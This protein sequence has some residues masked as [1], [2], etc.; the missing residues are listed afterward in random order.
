MTTTTN[1]QMNS[2]TLNQNTNNMTEEGTMDHANN[3]INMVARMTSAFRMGSVSKVIAAAA[4]GLALTISIGMSGTANA[5][6]PSVTNIGS[7][8]GSEVNDDFSL[9]YGTPDSPAK[10]I[11]LAASSNMTNDDFSLVYGTPDSPAKIIKLAASSNMTNDDF[12]LVYGTPDSPAKI[13]KLAASSN[14][15]NDDFSLVYGTPDSPAKITKLAASSNMTNDDFSL[16]YGTP[17][18]VN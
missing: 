8:L 9:V 4:V 15:T 17:D 18:N 10:I 14:M 13:I 12:S 7:Y 16:V 1:I 2:S 3:N 5:D 11:K 6:V